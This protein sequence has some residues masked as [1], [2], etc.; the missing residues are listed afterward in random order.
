VHL[1]F[2]ENTASQAVISFICLPMEGPVQEA[3][4]VATFPV[5][6]WPRATLLSCF[7]IGTGMHGQTAHFN[8]VQSMVPNGGLS[9]PYGLAVD[10]HGNV[11]VADSDNNQLFKE[12]LV[13]G[14]Y[15]ESLLSTPSLN[16]AHGV[17]VD[18]QGNVYIADSGNNRV[19]KET[20]SVSGYYTRSNVAASGL[21]DPQGVAVDALGNVYIADTEN[22][23]VLKE[24]PAGTGYSESTVVAGGMDD[25]EGVAVDAHGNVYIADAFHSRVVKETPAGTGYTETTVADLSSSSPEQPTGVAVDGAGNVYIVDYLDDEDNQVLKETPSGSGYVQSAVVFNGEQNPYG[26]AVDGSGNVYVAE[27]GGGRIE[28]LW[29]GTA[30]FGAV[31]IGTTSPTISIVF[32][33]DTGGTLGAPAV[34]TGGAAGQDFV[35]AGTGSCTYEGHAYLWNTGDTCAVDVNLR[36]QFPGTRLGAA[37]LQDGSGNALASGY[38]HG[39]GLGPQA[40]FPPGIPATIDS[41]LAEPAGVAVDALGNVFFAASGSGAV[42]EDALSSSGYR[43]TTVASG[44]SD[45]VGVA[46]DGR[47]NLFVATADGL[48]KETPVHG[49]YVQ[50]AIVSDLDH[51]SG[52]AVDGGGNLY[53]TTSVSGDAHKDT[54]QPDGSYRETA[55]GNGI[56]GPTGVTLDGSGNLYIADSRS[57]SVYKEAPQ[58]NGSYLQTVAVS[59][60]AEPVS[61]AVDGGGNLYLT[62][63]RSGD[64]YR[65]TLATGGSYVQSLAASGGAWGSWIALDAQG[66]LYLSQ[67][68]AVGGI[69]RIDFTQPAGLNFFQARVGSASANSPQTVTVAN[70]GTDAL[71]FPVPVS[72][73][74]PTISDSFVLAAAS[75]CPTVDSSGAIATVAPGTSCAYEISFMPTARGTVMGALQLRDTNLNAGWPGYA[76]QSIALRGTGMTSDATRTTMLVSANPITLGNWATVTV[77][78]SDG[79]TASTVVDGGDVV[80]SDS[81]GGVTVSLNGGIGIPLSAGKA[82]LHFV[83]SLAGA[84]TITAHYAGVDDRFA[85]STGQVSLSVE[86]PQR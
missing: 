41:G 78:V 68:T 86:G 45:P 57:G 49:S 69:T 10:S 52:L 79:T 30:D 56:S 59:G 31:E 51:L 62:S 38:V 34:L 46:I 50:S 73:E 60:V 12:D 5:S 11:Y 47:G 17:A 66:K 33:F 58:A 71:A 2:L 54:L 7:L 39:A 61:V 81:V 63:H 74:N 22:H 29:V 32:T 82:A 35:D 36:P 1:S 53:V 83:P 85:S 84:H 9:S 19:L 37:V 21:S 72:G 77:N 27:P 28:K 15:Y 3:P 48:F 64:V 42:Y 75:S 16:G 67:D 20:L 18:S 70:M 13:G 4:Q 55:I 25:P 26:I 6:A 14:V 44:L 80:F 24:T 43:R 40:I 8:S 23:R 65:E 76:V